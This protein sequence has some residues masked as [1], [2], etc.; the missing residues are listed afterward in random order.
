MLS[1]DGDPAWA[2][3][4]LAASERQAVR[5]ATELGGLASTDELVRRYQSAAV[6]V[7]PAKEEAFGMVLIESMACGTPAVGCTGSGM[8]EIVTDPA[9]GRLSR[10]GDPDDLA[11]ALDDAI[12]LAADPAT[13]A[14]CR[15][16]ATRF[17]WTDRIGPIHEDLYV[18]VARMSRRQDR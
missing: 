14:A 12:G 5:A 7:L 13:A 11:L 2:F 4:R 1:G 15:R 17:S 16:A 6:T 9:S 8:T 10:F 18:R 3:D